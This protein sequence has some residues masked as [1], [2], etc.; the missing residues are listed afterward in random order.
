MISFIKGYVAETTENSVI[1]ETDSI[2]YEIFM[3]GPAIEETSRMQDKIKIYTYFH[4]RDDAMQ[5]YGFLSRDDLEMFRLLL[6]VNGIGPKAAMGVLAAI[7]ADELRFAV[8]SD[9]VKTI[10]RAPGIGKKTAQ[11]LILELKDKLKLEDA[12]EKKLDHQEENLSLTDT[13]LRDSRQEAVEALTALGY[14]S[15]NALRAVRQVSEETGDDV[16]AILKA[17]LKQL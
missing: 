10:S 17:A 15:T 13:S 2:G 1:L 4:V 12:F 16:E 14:S 9:D 6:N 7:T 3:T 8:L 11:K 5:L